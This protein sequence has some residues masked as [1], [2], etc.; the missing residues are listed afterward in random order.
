MK[1]IQEII[2]FDVWSTTKSDFDN[3]LHKSN[4][5]FENS[6][7]LLNMSILSHEINI[8]I[9]L[10][11]V[12]ILLHHNIPRITII[13]KKCYTQIFYIYSQHLIQKLKI[14]PNFKLERSLNS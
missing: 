12:T 1:K 14:L 8:C 11:F 13:S 3:P 10:Y 6:L 7:L 5:L 4:K 2:P 9:E